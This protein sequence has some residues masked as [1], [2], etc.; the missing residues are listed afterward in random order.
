MV[1]VGC[2]PDIDVHNVVIEQMIAYCVVRKTISSANTTVNEQCVTALGTCAV[3]AFIRLNEDACQLQ[4]I[5][6]LPL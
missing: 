6:L 3:Q 2:I 1:N 4:C 5:Q